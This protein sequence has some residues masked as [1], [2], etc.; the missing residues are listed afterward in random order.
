MDT[1]FRCV[2]IAVIGAL[3]TLITKKQSGEFA[4][5]V[6]LAVVV[7]LGGMLLG[8][9]KPVLSFFEQMGERAKLSEEM[10]Q[11]VVRTLA[12]G[13]LTQCGKNICEEAGEKTVGQLLSTMGSIAAVYVLLPL[14]EGV[15]TLLEQLL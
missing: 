2:G 15:L 9:I 11:P 12:I 5:L 13:F 4:V 14:M 10:V 8:L 1:I 6:T 7:L 3:L